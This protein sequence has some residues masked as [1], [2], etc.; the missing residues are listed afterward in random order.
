MK[1]SATALIN[2]LVLF[3]ITHLNISCSVQKHTGSETTNGLTVAVVN[4]SINGKTIPG[5][6]VFCFSSTFNPDSGTGF[7]DTMHA[8]NNGEFSFSNLDS[9]VYNVFSFLPNRDSVAII[10]GINPTVPSEDTTVYYDRS[11]TISGVT[12]NDFGI[13]TNAEVYLIGTPFITSSNSTG[14][15][16]FSNVPCGIFIIKSTFSD[17]QIKSEQSASE[18]IDL[19]RSWNGLDFTIDLKLK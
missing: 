3:F 7:A 12:S 13:I 18:M 19:T 15:F 9:A 1:T 6:T 11:Y 2:A 16:I 17:R 4:S 5:N 8:D 14:K 10:Q